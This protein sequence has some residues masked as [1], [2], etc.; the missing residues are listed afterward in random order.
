MKMARENI[1]YTAG[2]L[3]Q[4][5]LGNITVG[6]CPECGYEEVVLPH[7]EDLHTALATALAQKPA[8]LAGPEIRFLR[9]YL[10][11]S[12]ADFAQYMGTTRETVSRWESEKKPIGAQADRLLRLLIVHLAPVEDYSTESLVGISNSAEATEVRVNLRD[13]GHWTVPAMA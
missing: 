2:G 1:R 10:G 7:I 8:R 12:A 6:R 5:I 9:T 4:V 11:W 13:S 3:P